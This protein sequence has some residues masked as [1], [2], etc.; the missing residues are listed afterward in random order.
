MGRFGGMEDGEAIMKGQRDRQSSFSSG[1][2][3]PSGFNPNLLFGVTFRAEGRARRLALF[4]IF[5]VAVPT[6]IV[7][8]LFGGDL[9]I[10]GVATCALLNLCALLIGVMALLARFT[11]IDVLFVPE[12]S[13]F[14]CIR[15]VKSGI[16]D[17]ERI[18]L[19]EG[20]LQGEQGSEEHNRDD[21]GNEFFV[22]ETLTPFQFI[23]FFTKSGLIIPKT[24]TMSR[25]K[26]SKSFN[27]GTGSYSSDL[28]I[29]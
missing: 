28:Q 15:C 26:F 20:T 13:P 8:G 12:R 16:L 22:H 5:S 11:R 10:L 6:A 21:D 4:F 1:P 7:K 23:P 24:S 3:H 17:G 25:E 18:L 27:S 19:T 14:V 9:G 2:F 29:G